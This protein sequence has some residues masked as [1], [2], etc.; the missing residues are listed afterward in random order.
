M[1]YYI[2][3]KGQQ[4]GPMSIGQLRLYKVDLNTQ[5]RDEITEEWKALMFYPELMQLY[6]PK[7][8]ARPAVP[9]RYVGH[10]RQQRS[11]TAT[12]DNRWVIW[13]VV[14]ILMVPV[15]SIVFYFAFYM[16]VL[17]FTTALGI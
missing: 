8:T 15:F 17:L 10:F 4:I 2:F 6:G 13:L 12:D 14:A 9:P 16:F 7:P 3:Y 11:D 1:Q 5:V